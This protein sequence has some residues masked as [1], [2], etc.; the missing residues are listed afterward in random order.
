MLHQM[1]CAVGG[2]LLT[3]AAAMAQTAYDPPKLTSNERGSM[4]EWGIGALFL[5]ACLVVA[6]KPAKRSNLR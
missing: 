2:V 1:V 3:A 6:F 5:I 4:A